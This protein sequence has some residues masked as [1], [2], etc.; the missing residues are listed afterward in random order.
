MYENEETR[1]GMLAKLASFK[2][3][4]SPK[5]W[6]EC[7]LNVMGQLLADKFCYLKKNQNPLYEEFKTNVLTFGAR[8][9]NKQ[10]E[11]YG[12]KDY[13]LVGDKRYSIDT[14]DKLLDD[15]QKTP[16]PGETL[17]QFLR[18]KFTEIKKLGPMLLD[19]PESMDISD[20]L[21]QK[22]QYG[23][24]IQG[25]LVTLVINAIEEQDNPSNYLIS[26][27]SVEAI[28]SLPNDHAPINRSI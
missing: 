21:T 12:V 15:F 18:I 22:R 19:K 5:K 7:S 28:R 25:K 11:F 4:C 13:F 20:W 14:Y 26:Q 3:P 9:E 6:M 2:W 17:E 10:D 24:N 23:Q 16:P 8:E 1:S 27:E